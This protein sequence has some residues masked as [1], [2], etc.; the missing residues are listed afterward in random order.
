MELVSKLRQRAAAGD[1]IRVGIVGCGQMG[2]AWP[3]RSTTSRACASPP[4]PISSRS[5]A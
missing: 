1:P 3:T 4:S 5:A 2:S